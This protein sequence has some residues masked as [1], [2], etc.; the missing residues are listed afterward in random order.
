MC[1]PRSDAETT[2]YTYAFSH[3]ENSHPYQHLI[4]HT[5]HTHTAHIHISYKENNDPK[6]L[7]CCC[8]HRRCYCCCC[9]WWWW[10]YCFFP[11]TLIIFIFCKT[12]LPKSVLNM[13]I[14]CLVIFFF[15]VM[16]EVC[17]LKPAYGL[18]G[19][20][21]RCATKHFVTFLNWYNFLKQFSINLKCCCIISW[22]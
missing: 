5:T 12:V 18:S 3:F 4:Q 19:R 16:Q 21:L 22:T 7:F 10:V 11:A 17:K 20:F 13:W 15:L 6:I 1:C 8:C 2:T 9:C 14:M